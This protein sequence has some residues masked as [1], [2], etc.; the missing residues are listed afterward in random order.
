LFTLIHCHNIAALNKKS[1]DAMKARKILMMR[2]AKSS[3]ED[4]SLSDF[5]RPLNSR[6]LRDAPRMGAWLRDSGIMPDLVIS[7]PAARAKATALHVTDELGFDRDEIVW[8]EN[9][10]FNGT[11]AYI[12]AV[13]DAGDDAETVMTVGHNPMTESAMSSLSD[14][15]FTYA[16]P[17]AAIACFE[18]KAE[19]WKDL[20]T[21]SC[22]L[23]WFMR[24]K[25]L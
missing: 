7:S 23:L 12:D 16:V 19:S 17:T 4:S 24:P 8:E 22:K 3:W 14:K 2:H 10:Y 6:G 20:K 18:L 1:A 5:D 9:L 11:R 25:D 13:R 21:G 15:A